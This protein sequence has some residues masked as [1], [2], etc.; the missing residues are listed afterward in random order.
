MSGIAFSNNIA[1]YYHLHTLL[2]D[3]SIQGDGCSF[4]L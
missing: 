1:R 3:Q 4:V 2:T